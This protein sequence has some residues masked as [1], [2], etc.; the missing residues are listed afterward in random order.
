[1][2]L[3]I[4]G[5]IYKTIRRLWEVERKDRPT[6]TLGSKEQHGDEFLEFLFTS[7]IPDWITE[8]PAT[9]TLQWTQSNKKSPKESLLPTTE[10]PE[11]KTTYQD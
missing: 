8:K 9:Q 7:Y 5:I 2:E 3:E 4:L 10:K 11:E 1:M 6:R